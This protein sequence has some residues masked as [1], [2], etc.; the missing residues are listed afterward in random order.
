MVTETITRRRK[1][2]VGRVGF[3]ALLVSGTALACSGTDEVKIKRSATAGSG[4]DAGEG[5]SSNGGSSAGK[6]G[7]DV[8]AAGTEPVAPCD[9][10]DRSCEGN[11]PR[12]CNGKG[13]WVLEEPCGGA[14]KVCTGKGECVPYRLLNAGI[15]SFG[16]R[17]AEGEIVLKEQ[18]L[19]AAPKSCGKVAGQNICVTGGIR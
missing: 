11:T 18:T 19:S 4:G 2:T 10:G 3:A 9:K 13:E 8:G 16:V 12:E 15:D 5:P 7:T 14:T 1:W 17:P 6:G